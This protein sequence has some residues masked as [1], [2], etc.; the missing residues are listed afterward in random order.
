[1]PDGNPAPPGRLYLHPAIIF[2]SLNPRHRSQEKVMPV[3]AAA[4]HQ[5]TSYYAHTL[6]MTLM[7]AERLLADI[8][9]D[10]FAHMPFPKLNH[11]AFNVGHLSLYPNRLFTMLGRPD[12]VIDKPGYPA[13]FQAGTECVEQ[14]GRYPSKDE[15]VSYYLERYRAMLAHLPEISDETL[16]RDNP[17][18]GRSREM[19]PTIGAAMCFLLNNHHMV[20]LGQISAW[21]RVMGLGSAM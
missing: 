2:A 8:P 19:F 17:V 12:L 15:L 9:E 10:R 14:D 7:Y 6:R 4:P 13:L 1:L 11:P 18:E 3:L 20:H 21:R 16:A 5:T